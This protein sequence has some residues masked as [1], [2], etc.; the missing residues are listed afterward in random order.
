M[1]DEAF[2]FWCEVGVMIFPVASWDMFL[3]CILYDCVEGVYSCVNVCDGSTVQ[4]CKVLFC[5]VCEFFPVGSLIVS[6]CVS[7]AIWGAFGFDCD[8]DWEVVGP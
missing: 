4:C 1:F 3:V 5:F 2:D 7:V 6:V 8:Y